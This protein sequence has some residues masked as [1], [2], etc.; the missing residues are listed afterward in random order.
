[1]IKRQILVVTLIVM[2]A[3]CNKELS[4]S[5]IKIATVHKGIQSFIDQVEDQNGL[6][7]YFDKKKA[8]YVFLNGKNVVQG[9]KATYFERF[10]AEGDGETLNIY[11]DEKSTEDYANQS[12]DYQ[13]LYKVNLDKDYEYIK[14][15]RNGKHV[16][17]DVASGN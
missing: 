17:I 1:M 16:P 12:V 14:A 2:L 11:F 4:Y 10:Y 7:V 13:L 8:V 3:G 6:Y 5:Y 15:F 9:E